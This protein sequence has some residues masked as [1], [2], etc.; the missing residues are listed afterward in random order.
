MLNG[1]TFSARVTIFGL[2]YVTLEWD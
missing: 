1:N 2:I